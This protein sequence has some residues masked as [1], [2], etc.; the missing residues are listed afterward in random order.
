MPPKPRR[1]EDCVVTGTVVAAPG[2]PSVWAGGHGGK[3][4]DGLRPA[5]A[6]PPPPRW[7]RRFRKHGGT[8]ARTEVGPGPRSPP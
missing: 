3:R 1:K 7:L 2:G 8:G 6:G 5:D 4:D